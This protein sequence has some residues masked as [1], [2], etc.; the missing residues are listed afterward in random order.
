MPTLAITIQTPSDADQDARQQ[1]RD[2]LIPFL[3]SLPDQPPH[4]SENVA[5]FDLYGDSALRQYL[6]LLVVDIGDGHVSA[7]L[8][9]E[10]L[11]EGTE[12]TPLGDFDPLASSPR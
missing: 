9:R 3:E 1:V 2:V 7:R 4:R 10:A 12:V 5:S 6:V 11:P 8:L